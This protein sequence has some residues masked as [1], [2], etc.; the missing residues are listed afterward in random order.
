MDNQAQDQP[1]MK[2]NQHLFVREHR[3]YWYGSWDDPDRER[4]TKIQVERDQC[5]GLFRQCRALRDI[6]GKTDN[7]SIRR[8]EMVEK[9]E[10]QGVAVNL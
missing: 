8:S 7:G 2:P 6:G 9:Y 1:V 5:W 4:V 10:Q 3:L